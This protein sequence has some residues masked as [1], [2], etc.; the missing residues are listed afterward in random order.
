MRTVHH[1]DDLRALLGEG[2]H[3]EPTWYLNG[4]PRIQGQVC[5]TEFYFIFCGGVLGVYF[6]FGQISTL[7]GNIDVS[8]RVRGSKGS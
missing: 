1:N 6:D 2:I 3:P 4:D 8:F 7:Q 5:A